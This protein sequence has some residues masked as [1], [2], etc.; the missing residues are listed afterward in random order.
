M[1]STIHANSSCINK[2]LLIPYN[3][4]YGPIYQLSGML[5]VLGFLQTFKNIESSA[6]L[7]I[8]IFFASAVAGLSFYLDSKMF[9]DFSPKNLKID[10]NKEYI[11]K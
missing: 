6:E 9:P 11:L 4:Y 7:F 5:A 8:N 3:K 2:L 10:S 1:E